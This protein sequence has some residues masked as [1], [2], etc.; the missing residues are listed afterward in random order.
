MQADH[1]YRPVAVERIHSRYQKTMQKSH[2]VHHYVPLYPA[3]LLPDIVVEP[4]KGGR[5]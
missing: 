2:R 1:L 5:V 3:C 4:P